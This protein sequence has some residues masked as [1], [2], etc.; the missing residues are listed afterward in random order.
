MKMFRF[1]QLRY[2]IFFS[3]ILVAVIPLLLTSFFLVRIFDMSLKRQALSEGLVQSREASELFDGLL[4]DCVLACQSL[5]Q[6][7][8]TILID[9]KN[10][11]IMQELYMFLYTAS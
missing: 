4:S 11:A 5:D 8:A 7:A 9:S 10:D 2:Q 3:C 6:S 1:V